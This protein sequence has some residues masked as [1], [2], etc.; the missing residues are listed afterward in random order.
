MIY[1]QE[2]YYSKDKVLQTRLVDAMHETLW[3]LDALY[4]SLN[5]LE[6]ESGSNDIALI[7]EVLLKHAAEAQ[8]ILCTYLESKVGEITLAVDTSGEGIYKASRHIVGLQ[9][10]KYDRLQ[11]TRE[12]EVTS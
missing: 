8:S 6:A 12:Q 7:I 10:E 2:R 11:V 9:I 1:I 3:P 4:R 5:E